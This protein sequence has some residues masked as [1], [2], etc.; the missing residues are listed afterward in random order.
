MILASLA[1]CVQITLL[2]YTN[3]SSFMQCCFKSFVD[4]LNGAGIVSG[5][6]ASFV[7]IRWDST[8]LPRFVSLYFT[9]QANNL[10]LVLWRIF[11]WP[12]YVTNVAYLVRKLL[13]RSKQ[14][15]AGNVNGYRAEI[16][17]SVCVVI[18]LVATSIS[19]DSIMRTQGVTEIVWHRRHGYRDTRRPWVPRAYPL[20]VTLR[21]WLS[22]IFS[23]HPSCCFS[24]N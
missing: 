18:Y 3:S 24:P 16:R 8:W 19:W 15:L 1:Y 14:L 12:S 6:V 11:Q 2:E 17:Y 7:T 9:L 22:Q 13:H 21:A 4:D 5:R 23:E 20:A 10:P